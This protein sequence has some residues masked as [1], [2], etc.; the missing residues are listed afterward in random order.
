MAK[1]ESVTAK[2]GKSIIKD[3][4]KTVPNTRQPNRGWSRAES[5][6]A[7]LVEIVLD[8]PELRG[9]IEAKV[10][11][12]TRTGHF[13][14]GESE[15][16][17]KK[18]TKQFKGLKWV[19]VQKQIFRNLMTYSNCFI[20][21]VYTDSKK[22]EIKGFKV[23][24]TPDIEV[25]VSETGTIYKFKQDV[26]SKTD[27]KCP[28]WIAGKDMIKLTVDQYTSSIWGSSNIETLRQLLYTKKLI[29]EH[30]EWL[31]EQNMFKTNLHFKSIS[32]DDVEILSE[33]I[34]EGMKD[35]KKMLL[36]VSE[37]QVQVNKL[38]DESKLAYLTD[39]LGYYRMQI[40]TLLQVP[41]IISGTVDNSNRSN[42]EIQARY[43]FQM[44]LY[45]FLE[46]Y[47][48]EINAELMP[49][50]GVEGVE[51]AHQQVDLKDDKELVDIAMKLMTQ[52]ADK[53]KVLGW[54]NSKGME[55]P[56]DMFDM[57][58]EAQEKEQTA[59]EEPKEGILDK[60]NPFK[61]KK[62]FP[63]N[64]DLHESRQPQDKGIENFKAKE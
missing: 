14:E 8:D 31:F 57:A 2:A 33:L 17:V 59:E 56:E 55:L 12:L 29:L 41:P 64:S 50:I 6:M 53:K 45:S 7:K 62:Q 3:Y 60:I 5:S 26:T 13:F 34:K 9:A 25:D 36:T 15:E 18:V 27:S 49:L 21:I 44:S 28:T 16:N 58:Q 51:I 22:T 11:A 54:L 40:L 39:L 37:E 35:R 30:I 52:G 32:V 1:K 43:A 42:S 38:D 47:D 63:P 10:N 4:Y 46:E 61:K 19:K 23:P 48:E 20:E 24:D